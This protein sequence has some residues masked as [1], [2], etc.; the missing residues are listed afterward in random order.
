MLKHDELSLH[1]NKGVS[2]YKNTDTSKRKKDFQ[3]T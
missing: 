3:Q 1:K 2:V